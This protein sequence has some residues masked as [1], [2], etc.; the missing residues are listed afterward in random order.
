MSL[1][2]TLPRRRKVSKSGI[3]RAPKRHWSRH[4]KWVRGHACCVPGCEQ[5]PIEFAHLRSAANAGTGMKPHSA[6]GVSLCCY[7][8]A[9]Q[10]AIGQAQF[11]REYGIDLWAL[12]REF[13]RRSPDRAM[14]ESLA[15]VELENA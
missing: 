11:E 4:E 5:T 2:Y 12:A 14:K 8:H 6:F 9:R 3:E 1:Q 15:L 10:H 13:T 7:H